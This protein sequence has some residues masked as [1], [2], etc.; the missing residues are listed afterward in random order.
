M[1]SVMLRCSV[2]AVVVIGLWGTGPAHAKAKNANNAK[3]AKKAKDNQRADPAKAVEQADKDLAAARKR[4]AEAQN[5]LARARA[6]VSKAVAAARNE[7]QNSP[8][9]RDAVQAVAAARENYETVSMPVLLSLRDTPEYKKALDAQ[10]AADR[11]KE[12]GLKAPDCD[13]ARRAKLITAAADARTVVSRIEQEAL[14]ANPNCVAARKRLD[15]AI[16]ALNK[17]RADF[18]AGLK[19]SAEVTAARERFGPAEENAAKAAE[20]VRDAEKARAEAAKRRSAD[21]GRDRQQDGRR[22][23][24]NNRNNNRNNNKGKKNAGPGGG[25]SLPRL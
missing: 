8:R 24:K 1:K 25:I 12:E 5:D 2:C 14:S 9:L 6:A 22:K 13:D 3:N 4:A 15:E 21:N 18:E 11:E 16:A 17:L 7:F 19:D 10:D 20:D 23:G